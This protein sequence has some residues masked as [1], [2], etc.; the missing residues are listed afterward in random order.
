MAARFNG[1]CSDEGISETWKGNP[2]RYRH[3]QQWFDIIHEPFP[4]G[5][6]HTEEGKE[7]LA[8]CLAAMTKATPEG[9][10]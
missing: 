4:P 6:T 7:L 3:F 1:T 2:E 10:L 8:K 5:S 9:I